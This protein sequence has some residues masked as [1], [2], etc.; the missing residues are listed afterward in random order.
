M[1]VLQENKRKVVEEFNE[2]NVTYIDL[3]SWTFADRFMAFLLSI[4][5]FGYAV[6]TYPSPRVKEEVP[7]WVLICCALQMKLHTTSSFSRLPGILG[8]G[9]VLSRLGYNV[10]DNPG[11]G[12]NQKNR[13]D[14]TCR[15]IR[16][17]CVSFTKTV[18][19]CG[20]VTGTT[21]M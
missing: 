20:I 21:V 8:S 17:A 12:F 2:G 4:E 18:I 10:A 9:A 7:R 1:E 11:G 3:S 13:T 5:F 16:T 15:S 14:R 19:T 6:R